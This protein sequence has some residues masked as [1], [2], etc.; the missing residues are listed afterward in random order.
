MYEVRVQSIEMLLGF[1]NFIVIFF[2]FPLYRK[3][4]AK[5]PVS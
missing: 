2:Y 4:C 1:E 3:L 5:E